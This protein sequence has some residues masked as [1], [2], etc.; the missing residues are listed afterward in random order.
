MVSDN[1]SWINS[2]QAYGYGQN[3]ST[4]VMEQWSKFK[5]AQQQNGIADPKLVCIDIAPYGS[6]QAP[7]REDILNVG[8]FSDS[9]FR[10]VGNFLESD[11]ARFVR[12]VEA[13]EL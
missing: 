10:V 11:S 5:K 9:V 4:G 7:D 13:V 3:G 8:G 6:S 1:Q 12:E 2:G